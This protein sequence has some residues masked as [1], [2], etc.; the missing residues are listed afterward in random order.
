MPHT[1]IYARKSTESEDRQ[2]LSI[3]S[4]VR[5]LKDFAVRQ[6][7][8]VDEVYTESQSAKKLGRPIFTKVLQLVNNGKID[9][10]ICWKL[11]RLA[12]N[13]IDGGALIWALDEGRLKYIHSPQRSFE[14]TG[15]DK[16]WMQLEFG[17][18]KKYVDDLSDNVRRGQ[19]EKL[20]QGWLPG[21]APIGYINEK[22]KRTI[23]PDPVRFPLIRKMW[24]LMLTGSYSPRRILQIATEDWGL[25]TRETKRKGGGPLALS[26]VYGLFKQPFYYGAILR[27]GQLSP[28][29]HEPMIRKS[30]FDKVQEMLGR[31]SL[32]RPK[33]REFAFTGLIMCG[34]C[35]AG[36]TAEHKLQRH[37]HRYVYYHCT[38]RKRGRICSQRGVELKA[39]E[40]QIV[41]FLDSI[42]VSQS[43]V[44]WASWMLQEMYGDDVKREEAER[45]SLRRRLD[46][47]LR[48]M[49][50]LVNMKLRSMVDDEE[51]TTKRNELEEERFKIR[52]LLDDSHGRFSRVNDVVVEAFNFAA[53]ARSRFE[54]GS[55]E[56][57][58]AVLAYTGSNLNLVNKTLQIEPQMPLLFMQRALVGQSL[59]ECVFEPD[60]FRELQRQAAGGRGPISHLWDVIKDVRTYVRNSMH[61]KS[62]A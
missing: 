13:P 28:G 52:E 49:N 15:N 57:K 10:V 4:Q 58:R 2:I 18:A 56:D 47:C 45:E 41:G 23:V 31:T 35:G 60:Y 19:R 61:E 36:V 46:G 9:Q 25:T 14:N 59:Q 40:S 34:E 50:E 33:T 55:L 39:L 32:A 22:E 5:E 8:K 48:E 42:T 20:L 3:D 7:L 11:D 17:M 12:R 53:T 1:V 27:G 26:A 51:Y 38:K 21:P 30:D 62:G 43:V 37:G 44:E 6:G 16:F 29:S 24:D 54:N